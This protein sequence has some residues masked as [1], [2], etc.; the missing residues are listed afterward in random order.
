MV[1][2]PDLDFVKFVVA[3]A[4]VE[5]QFGVGIVVCVLLTHPGDE[6]EVLV[7]LHAQGA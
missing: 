3:K 4:T 6:G 2:G 1:K 7:V 5:L